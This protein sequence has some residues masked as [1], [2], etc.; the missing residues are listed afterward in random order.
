MALPLLT[1]LLA[2][3]RSGIARRIERCM[4]LA[5]ELERRV[6]RIEEHL[7]LPPVADI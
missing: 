2:W 6:L 4:Q 5:E 1:M 7:H 3:G